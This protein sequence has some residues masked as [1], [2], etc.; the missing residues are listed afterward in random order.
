MIRERIQDAIRS[1]GLSQREVARIAGVDETLISWFV[2]GQR[3]MTF[4]TID[5]LMAGLGLEIVIRHRRHSR[6]DG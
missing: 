2:R 4:K 1:T 6:K 5:Q 3:E